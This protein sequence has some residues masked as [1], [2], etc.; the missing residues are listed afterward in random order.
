MRTPSL[1]VGGVVINIGHA[2]AVQSPTLSLVGNRH[3][4]PG[5]GEALVDK[6]SWVFERFGGSNNHKDYGVG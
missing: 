4:E 5:K 3:G 2:V 1:A 6:M